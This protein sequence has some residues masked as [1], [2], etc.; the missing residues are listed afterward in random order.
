MTTNIVIAVIVFCVLCFLASI[1][2]QGP[3]GNY[4][5]NGR[6]KLCRCRRLH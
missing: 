2:D 6:A 1:D 4:R 5:H 3:P